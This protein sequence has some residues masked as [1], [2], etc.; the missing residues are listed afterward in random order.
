MDDKKDIMPSGNNTEIEAEEVLTGSIE[1]DDF[2][3]IRI[4]DGINTTE[5]LG[6]VSKYAQ[7]IN[8][9]GIT[10]EIEATTKYVVR[11]PAEFQ[12]AL[13]SGEIFVTENQKTGV[14]WPSLY[15]IGEDGKHTLIANMPIEEETF[16]K[17]SIST[18][19]LADAIGNIYTQRMLAEISAAVEEVYKEVKKIEQGQADD[20]YGLLLSGR[21]QLIDAMKLEGQEKLLAI[22]SG[23][24]QAS[25]AQKQIYATLKRRIE[26]FQ[27][28]PENKAKL[29]LMEMVGL[30]GYCQKKDS[31][32]DE[33]QD[34]YA[35][36]LNATRLVAASYAM[37][38][39][40]ELVDDTFQ[41]A[42]TEI[43]EIAMGNIK[44]MH[45]LHEQD[46]GMFYHNPSGFIEAEKDTCIEEIDGR[47]TVAVTVSGKKLLE[48]LKDGRKEEISEAIA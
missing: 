27:P 22:Q 38:G 14:K 5:V 1:D 45:N 7:C 34:Y 33:I 43:L 39:H 47:S 11:I 36:Y 17:V 29:F 48:V 18:G 26:T 24:S 3:E 40:Q 19:E 42:E 12:K 31:E 4:T 35:L 13:E 20:R 30:N 6:F 8:L 16:S 25:E 28:I 32:F 9:A 10:G 15:K 21:Q 46:E 41:R 2:D 23:R 44:T 37:N